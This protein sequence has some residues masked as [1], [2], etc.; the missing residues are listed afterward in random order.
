MN[1]IAQ[2]S[3]V[4]SLNEFR[5]RFYRC[6]KPY[7]D[8]LFELTDALLISPSPVTSLPMLSVEPP[9]QRKHG[10]LY[11]ALADGRIDRSAFTD[12][13][14][15]SAPPD[16]P[17]SLRRRH[18]H[19]SPPRCRH[20]S[21]QG[22]LLR[23]GHWRTPDCTRLHVLPDHPRLVQSRLVDRTSEYTTLPPRPG[24]QRRDDRTDT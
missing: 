6:L 17:P 16:W 15:S 8:T 5:S 11:R 2:P 23:D 19:I 3:Q 20:Q 21:R 13:L 9:F 12:L 10:S 7:G 14:A 24:P 18:Q 4:L 22:V 1:Q